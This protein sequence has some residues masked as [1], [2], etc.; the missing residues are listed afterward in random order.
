[1]VELLPEFI[2][3]GLVPGAPPSGRDDPNS[4]DPGYAR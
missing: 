3:I 2:R 1:M 4:G